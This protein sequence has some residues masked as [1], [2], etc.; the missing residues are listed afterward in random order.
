MTVTTLSPTLLSPQISPFPPVCKS[1]LLEA[2]GRFILC[3]KH[4]TS[5]SARV[6]T[7]QVADM[8]S[9]ISSHF[10]SHI[11][12]N[13]E[14]GS[15]VNCR[16]LIL[17]SSHIFF[18]FQDVKI[19]PWLHYYS[20]LHPLDTTT[21]LAELLFSVQSTTRGNHCYIPVIISILLT[22]FTVH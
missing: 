21:E 6:H 2:Q 20:C 10:T 11:P 8:R 9:I 3:S 13:T 14:I 7:T 12:P 15:C 5:S 18:P 4:H 19:A 22:D 17:H 1:G 16:T